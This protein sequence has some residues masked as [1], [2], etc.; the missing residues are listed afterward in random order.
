MKTRVSK[1]LVFLFLALGS[2]W[3]ERRQQ[4]SAGRARQGCPAACGRIL[5]T[6]TIPPS[7]I[8]TRDG[9]TP[10]AARVLRSI[11]PCHC[12]GEPGLADFT[13]EGAARSVGGTDG[14]YPTV[15][16]GAQGRPAY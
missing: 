10:D 1:K 2:L 5:A 16:D 15:I 9:F 12:L 6:V 3:R 4:R 7:T 14:Y 13:T 11:C 8:R